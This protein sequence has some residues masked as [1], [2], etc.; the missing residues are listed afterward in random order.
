LL[1][2][3][4][5]SINGWCIGYIAA[6]GEPKPKDRPSLFKAVRVIVFY[7]I[8]IMLLLNIISALG[9]GMYVH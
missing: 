7:G 3:K 2:L 9:G 4:F 6:A 1:I 8:L 5:L